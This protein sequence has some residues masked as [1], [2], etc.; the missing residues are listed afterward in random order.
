MLIQTMPSRS[1]NPT[2]VMSTHDN[3]LDRHLSMGSEEHDAGAFPDEGV[4]YVAT[5]S[6][7][8]E[9]Y[10]SAKSLKACMSDIHIT[11]ITE[12]QPTS[13]CFD[14]W[15]PI[16]SPTFTALDKALHLNQTP[17]R[18]TLFLDSDTYVARPVEDIFKLLD[19][20]DFLGTIEVSRGYWYG[21]EIKVP[22]TFPEINGGV[23]A[24]K[25][26]PAVRQVMDRWH[27]EILKTA[28][29]QKNYGSRVWDQ[30]ALRKLLW[31][32]RRE[33]RLGILPTE[34]NIISTW[35][36]YIYGSPVII[37]TRHKPEAMLKQVDSYKIIDRVWLPQIGCVVSPYNMTLPKWFVTFFRLQ[38]VYFIAL[39]RI[40]KSSVQ[41]LISKST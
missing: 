19:D 2:S 12:V 8:K 41:Q 10:L 32:F 28:S 17:Y 6:Y 20:Y 38:A 9:A 1:Q 24:F 29:W 13:G 40:L 11:V 31:E 27:S 25:K 30:P 4:V 5:G 23:L 21:D 15:E 14:H 34:Y 26:T 33:L 7:L 37:H 35:G 22:K 18:K 36:S 16:E 39:G 3:R